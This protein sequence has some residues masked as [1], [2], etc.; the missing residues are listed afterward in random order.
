MKTHT[1]DLRHLV[2]VTS[3]YQRNMREAEESTH[4]QQVIRM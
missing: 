3:K 2:R 4:T 1:K